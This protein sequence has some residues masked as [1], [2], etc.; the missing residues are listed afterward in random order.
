MWPLSTNN[1]YTPLTDASMEPKDQDLTGTW[2]PEPF[3]K[4]GLLSRKIHCWNPLK[5]HCKHWIQNRFELCHLSPCQP[6][7]QIKVLSFL[8]SF[9]YSISFCVPEVSS[10]CSV[11]KYL[12]RNI[13]NYIKSH[14][15]IE[16][17]WWRHYNKQC[18]N[19]INDS[20]M[21]KVKC[22]AAFL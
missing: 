10:P 12:D 15:T 16:M 2:K 13:L 22:F 1:T 14:Q 17:V 5:S 19:G 6:N 21:K 3:Q 18:Q 7:S 8:R 20:N 11:T 9:C 4:K